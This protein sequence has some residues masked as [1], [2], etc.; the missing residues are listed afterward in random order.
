MALEAENVRLRE[1]LI[2]AERGW[3]DALSYASLAKETQQGPSSRAEDL[4]E[5]R[6]LQHEVNVLQRQ[7]LK[8][9]QMADEFQRA[10]SFST[11]EL[12]QSVDKLMIYLH[13]ECPSSSSGSY[14]P[15]VWTLDFPS[16]S[17][18]FSSAHL[19]RLGKTLRRLQA[20]AEWVREHNLEKFPL[21]A[22]VV[23]SLAEERDPE[24]NLKAGPPEVDDAA[25]E[26]TQ[27]AEKRSKSKKKKAPA[28]PSVKKT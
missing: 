6:S 13:A 28:V 25:T 19:V 3:R 2:F 12:E 10:L 4:L 5:I 11:D 17:E 21:Y 14:A 15:P 1:A 8:R 27:K 20:V 23:R 24:P 26:N 18:I 22:E 9:A 16:D 7:I